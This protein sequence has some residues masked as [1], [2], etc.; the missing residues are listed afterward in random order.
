MPAKASTSVSLVGDA[1]ALGKI[2]R[3][4]AAHS[5]NHVAT[6]VA[7]EADA[8]GNFIIFGI[9][10]DVLEYFISDTFSFEG[11]QR[12]FRPAGLSDSGIGDHHDLSRSKVPGISTNQVQCANAVNELR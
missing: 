4:A 8:S 2:H 7:K 3:T 12:L 6:G 9:R 10:S 11:G 1:D 5:Q